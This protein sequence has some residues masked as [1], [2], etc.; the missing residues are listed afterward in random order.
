MRVG[1]ILERI[2]ALKRDILTW[3]EHAGYLKPKLLQRGRL[4]RR[5][6][7][8]RDFKLIQAM[9]PYYNQGYTSK[10]AYEKALQD[11]GWQ[12]E[13][14]AQAPPVEK[15]LKSIYETSRKPVDTFFQN[16]FAGKELSLDEICHRAGA[17]LKTPEYHETLKR[18]ISFLPIEETSSGRYRYQNTK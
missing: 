12:D 15:Q 7:G 4:R 11:L 6:Y 2:P 1:E 14:N 10:T 9:W 3:W 18:L 16:I 17:V 13:A 8:E 5:I